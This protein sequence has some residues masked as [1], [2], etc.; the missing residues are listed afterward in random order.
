MGS[1]SYQLLTLWIDLVTGTDRRYRPRKSRYRPR[2]NGP[3]SDKR[4]SLRRRLDVGHSQHQC[5]EHHDREL[6]RS[7]FL[8]ASTNSTLNRLS[9]RVASSRASVSQTFRFRASRRNWRVPSTRKPIADHM[10]RACL[11]RPRATS[12][13]SSGTAAN[14]NLH[15]KAASCAVPSRCRILAR[16]RFVFFGHS[17]LVGSGGLNFTQSGCAPSRWLLRQHQFVGQ[18][19]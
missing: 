12:L 7:E 14:R 5:C 16:F 10:N 17:R 11:M 2:K 1:K 8:T 18:R 6:A 19:Q 9:R 15:L 13:V 4:S 3:L